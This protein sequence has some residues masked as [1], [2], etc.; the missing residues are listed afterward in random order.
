[1]YFIFDNNDEYTGIEFLFLDDAVQHL[2]HCPP[3]YYYL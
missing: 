2:V 3:G 1:M